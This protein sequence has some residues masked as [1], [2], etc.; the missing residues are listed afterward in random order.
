MTERTVILIKPDAV[1]RT[2]IGKIV[3][4]Y[5]ARGLRIVGMKLMHADRALTEQHYDEHQGKPFFG[6]LVDFITSSP[7]V[8]MCVEGPNAIANCRE[9][10]GKTKPWEALPG[11]IRG[12]FALDTGRN[13]VHASDSAESAA[14]EVAL[15]FKPAELL[16]YE[17]AIDSWVLE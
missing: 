16:D 15:W 10:N 5:E 13:L 9:I 4:R 3:D 8:A 17:R 1:Q 14:R 11:T 12:D 2:L 6:G 7:L